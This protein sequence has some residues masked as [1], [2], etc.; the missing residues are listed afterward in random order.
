[1]DSKHN[2]ALT[3]NAKTLRNNMTPQERHLWFD[4][5]RAYP[6]KILRQK[7]IGNYIVDFYCAKAKLVI[8]LDGSQ[9]SSKEGQLYDIERTKLL[10]A[11]GLKVIRFSNEEI[12][13][14]FN[15]VCQSIDIEIK[16]KVN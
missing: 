14:N 5:L 1:M 8:E 3:P 10:N 13:T 9:H 12:D 7:I 11:F 4:F 15:D 6:V 16:G 2:K